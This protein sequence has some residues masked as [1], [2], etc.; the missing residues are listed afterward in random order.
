MFHY[1]GNRDPLINVS[2]EHF[3]NQ[4]NA[5]FGKRDKGYSEGV[6]E[7]LINVIERVFLVDDRVEENAQG[8]HILL[9]A[10]VRL[11]LKDFWCRIV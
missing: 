8:P 4:V 10:S 7:D 5:R 2:V 9:F 1:F 3:S 11:A 6:V